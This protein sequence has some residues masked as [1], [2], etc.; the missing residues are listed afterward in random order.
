MQ[1]RVV[2]LGDEDSQEDDGNGEVGEDFWYR[3][4]LLDVMASSITS[5]RKNFY[6]WSIYSAAIAPIRHATSSMLLRN[7]PACVW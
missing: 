7:L 2:D 4:Q 3:N 5:S 1:D 6:L